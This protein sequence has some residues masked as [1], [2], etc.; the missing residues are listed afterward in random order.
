M[1]K[2]KTDAE[3]APTN[4]KKSNTSKEY[5]YHM[6]AR[7]GA[8]V[9]KVSPTKIGKRP[10][11][12]FFID[13]N[14]KYFPLRCMLDLG[15]T[16]FVISPEAT[17]AFQVPVVKRKI[18]AKA[19][20][21]GGRKIITE[22][23]F[24]IPLG[25]SFG[26]HRTS[27]VKDHAFEVMKTSSEYDALIP[28]WYLN[29]HKA[30]GITEG[31]LHFPMCS[32]ECFGHGKIHPEYAITYDK[33]I[34]L[35]PDAMHIGSSLFNTPDVLKKLPPQYHK[36]L[37]RFDPQESEKLPDN[38][39]CDHRIEFK[40]AEENLRM[41]PIYQLTIEE[42]RLLKEYLDKMIKEGKIRPSSSPIGS[43]ILFVAKPNGKGLRLCVDYRH[44][45][46]NK[47]KDKTLL[48]IMQEL[49]DRL[50]GADFITKVDLKAGFHLIRM[51]LGHEKFTAFR[52][53]F[54]L[55]EYMVM[56]FGLTNAPATFQREINRILRPVL[57]IEL[58]NNHT[59]HTDKDEGMVVVAYINNIIIATKGSRE[60][61]RR[62]VGKVFDVL[63]ENQMCVELDKCVF[64]QTEASFL[65]FIVSGKTIQMD[66]AKAQDIVDWPRPKNQ[67]EVQ[68]V[69]GLWNLYGRFIPNY[70]QIVA[71][72]TDLLRGNS[73]EFNFGEAQEASFLK[74]VV[75]FTSGMTP[76]LRHF[77]QERPAL[78]ETDALDFAIGAVL[79]P[80]FEDGK[81]HPCA[82][83]SRKLSP[84]EFNY[85]VFD[86]E[87][88]AIVYTFQKWRHYVLGTEH[89]TTIFTDHQNLENFSK[90]VKLNRRQA[91]WAEILMEFDFVIVYLKGSLNQKADILSWCPAYTF[92]EGGTTAIMEKPM[93]GPDQWLEIGAMEIYDET[94]E[95][96][97]IGALEVALLSSDQK[98]AIIQDAKLDDEYM[99]ICKA[100]SKGEK[101][102]DH[103]SIQEDLLAWK[104]RIY[105]PK[106]MR[107]KVMKSEHDLKI[108]G[109]F[110]RGR[111]MELISRNFFWPKM[112]DDVQ[113]HCN[114]C[115]NCQQT[116]SPRHA[117]HG[118][119]HP[120][121]LPSK[122][123]RHISTDFITNLPESSGYTKILV[124]V[125]RFTKMAHFIPLSKK[126]SPTVAKAYLENVWKYHGFP[127][128]VVSDRDGTFTGQYF[129]DLY[130]YLG[131]K[132]SMSTAFHPQTDG[133]TERIN[134]VIEAYLRS[135]CNYEQNDWAEML[136]MAE[137]A[138]NNSKHSAM[139]IS[140]F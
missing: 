132:R 21:V 91:R 58:V 25:L 79:S 127:E 76:I 82:Y 38:K 8:K 125:D 93:L 124:V 2:R 26:N 110:R 87:M 19:S 46:S 90:K 77:D 107:K 10:I 57:E 74:I 129:T 133:Q 111:T 29:E 94:L 103:Y 34:A 53:K 30:Q 42:E 35:R 112:E 33:K 47:I 97:D 89:K 120:L 130:N 11:Y 13:F 113:Q 36:W 4:S 115:D 78:I 14:G 54:G 28:A 16:S 63:L 61:H 71:P 1:S 32:G 109:H 102:D 75:L 72:I 40:T 66:P 51:M 95:S 122:P 116:K 139:K 18:P 140:P 56:P 108:A 44:L 80:M 67:K 83:L 23:L 106:A 135:Y 6:A 138:Y 69:L 5:V 121:G 128:D 50:R 68:Q 104:G 45:N 100:V 62:Q 99:R 136:G 7:K 27:H 92:R 15:S 123:W 117:K 22:A 37:L 65:G 43:P 105:V 118:L 98:E 131:I 96:I 73:K 9:Y 48:P 3:L 52:T 17:R 20:D 24:T 41:E 31:R 137:F 12:K 88:L 49:Q 86:K 70:A 126:D 119:L 81:I 60:K 55:F 84:G 134:Q 85:N 39:G 64:E 114:E 101:V 59:I